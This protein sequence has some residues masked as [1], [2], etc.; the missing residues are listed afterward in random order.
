MAGSGVTTPA[1][2]FVDSKKVPSALNWRPPV[3][4]GAALND[5]FT[6]VASAFMRAAAPA[7]KAAGDEDG[8]IGNIT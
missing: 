6:D 3:P 7:D 4:G 2:L 5:R 1:P 8:T